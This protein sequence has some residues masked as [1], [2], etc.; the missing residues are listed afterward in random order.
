[1]LL[2]QLSSGS[3]ADYCIARERI[4]RR[5]REAALHRVTLVSAPAGFGKSTA[6]AQFL[7]PAGS[8]TIHYRVAPGAS[9]LP[10]FLRG[11]AD[12]A[13]D[14]LPGLRQSFAIVYE[15]A[16][17]SSSAVGIFASWLV[18]HASNRGITLAI[19][20]LHH[21]PS[22]EVTRFL[23]QAVERAGSG[24]SWILADR[25]VRFALPRWLAAGVAG[26][27][28]DESDLTFTP[29]EID[30]LASAIGART[31][32]GDTPKLAAMTAGRA[33][34]LRLALAS[35]TLRLSTRYDAAA[36]SEELGRALLSGLRKSG[37]FLRAAVFDDIDVPMLRA[38]GWEDASW[39]VDT[40][41][42]AGCLEQLFEGRYRIES[43]FHDLLLRELRNR[44]DA[45]VADAMLAAAEV[46]ERSQRY[47]EA[48][49]YY[50]MVDD[51][52]AVIRLLKRYGLQLVDSGNADVVRA[53]MERFVDAEPRSGVLLALNAV[54]AA[55][56]GHYDAAEAWFSRAIARAADP[57]LKAALVY[58]HAL[59]L[60]R[61]GKVDCIE[62]L[63]C[64]ADRPGR[65]A[66]ALQATLATAY[67]IANRLDDAR[68]WAWRARETLESE[69]T[70]RLDR[71]RTIHQIA[72][73]A[74]R[75]GDYPEAKRF[76]SEA[77]AIALHD[78]NYD[79][80]SRA[81]SVLYELA[82][83]A[84]C[85]PVEAL[86][87]VELVADS[88]A[89]S[90]DAK[91]R[92]WALMAALYI[93][94]ERFNLEAVAAIEQALSAVDLVQNPEETG[95][96][97]LPMEALRAAW[98][99]D[100]ARA[101]AL[102]LESAE[103]QMTPDRRGMR[104]AEIALYAA[105][106]GMRDEAR[107][108]IGSA[109]WALRGGAPDTRHSLQAQAYLALAAG[110]IFDN[111]GARV[112]LDRFDARQLALPVPIEALVRASRAIVENW[113]GAANHIEVLD[114]FGAMRAA[115]LGGIAAL[116]EA[117]PIPQPGVSA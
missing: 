49:S 60:L 41:L 4:M 13:I 112:R 66:A 19:D 83:V 65:L 67:A 64:Y 88:A 80:A 29:G 68:R 47:A 6:L 46:F 10:A 106:A 26:M 116:F 37:F 40:L 59:D 89:K 50:S 27:P 36:L 21:A 69:S 5:L 102:L 22:D 9:T 48:L 71:A 97:L 38:A 63:E 56:I 23:V 75:C 94:A 74:L 55:Q 3:G 33:S 61:R 84:E 12:A 81:Y 78:G 73:V 8:R 113:A 25:S 62:S 101:H 99:R 44:G 45:A 108:A 35:P 16:M 115:H 96:T 92:V 42:R 90:G 82:H 18:E 11:L 30:E 58:R 20:D 31:R 107:T 15:R 51:R 85:D 52:E 2:P 1:M 103:V 114:A 39:D 57:E 77:V 72:Y 17:R 109:D 53:A 100:F 87:Y 32:A 43:E 76:S 54:L 98:R 79:L 14:V 86:R 7:R 93:E 24:V 34:A 105:A 95:E 117:L 91:V 110:L 28:L 111:E 70:L 104:F